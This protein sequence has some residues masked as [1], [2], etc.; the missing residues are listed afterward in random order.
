MIP[1]T[2]SSKI[3]SSPAALPD[4]SRRASDRDREPRNKTSAPP[5]EFCL[6]CSGLLVP[7]YTASLEWDITG[8]PVTLWRC[9]NCGDCVDRVILANRWEGSIPAH[10]RTRTSMRYS[11]PQPVM[12]G[13]IEVRIP[14]IE[15]A[16]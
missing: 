7:S 15:E 8:L 4:V 13:V 1:L 6:R 11:F 10:T 2:G 12:N 14:K 3:D 16:K 9:V 5:G